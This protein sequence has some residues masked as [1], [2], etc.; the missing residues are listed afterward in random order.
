LKIGS[1]DGIPTRSSFSVVTETGPGVTYNIDVN[2]IEQEKWKKVKQWNKWRDEENNMNERFRDGFT[3][4][5][6]NPN[7][8]Q[9]KLKDMKQ[10]SLKYE[11]DGRR[12]LD[13]LELRNGTT[14]SLYEYGIGKNLIINNGTELNIYQGG[15]GRK[16]TMNGGKLTIHQGG[17][18][19]KLTI[20]SGKL[21]IHQGGSGRKLTMNGGTG[22][23]VWFELDKNCKEKESIYIEDSKLENLNL[24]VGGDSGTYENVVTMKD[25][26]SAENT[27]MNMNLDYN[28]LLGKFK[29]DV[30]NI[31]GYYKGN[32][33]INLNSKQRSFSKICKENWPEEG[34]K[35]IDTGKAD[36][37]N[38]NFILKFG[39][40]HTYYMTKTLYL[41]KNINSESGKCIG[42]YLK[43]KNREKVTSDT[44]EKLQEYPKLWS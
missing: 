11:D 32:M 34:I 6:Y 33:V 4:Y 30:L 39:K 8:P 26:T 35:L 20:N 27:I 23:E 21:T 2:G 12:V 22:G 19:R 31:N 37:V 43:L 7:K 41:E 9:A 25:I 36:N 44:S 16:L 38:G 13:G 14:V 1:Y 10:F 18:G 3:G 17:S 40:Y 42:W 15:L 5:M 24:H 28:S 29:Y